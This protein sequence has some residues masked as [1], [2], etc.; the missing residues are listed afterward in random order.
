MLKVSLALVLVKLGTYDQGMSAKANK[1]H[2]QTRAGF[3]LKTWIFLFSAIYTV[4]A[5]NKKLGYNEIVA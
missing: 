2:K 5:G 3:K 4:K 1:S